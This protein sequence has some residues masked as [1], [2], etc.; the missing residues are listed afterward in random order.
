[1]VPTDTPRYPLESKGTVCRGWQLLSAQAVALL[2][3]GQH[4]GDAVLG[5]RVLSLAMA[6]RPSGGTLG[7][8]GESAALPRIKFVPQIHQIW[9]SRAEHT[10]AGSTEGDRASGRTG[11]LAQTFFNTYKSYAR[12]SLMSCI[13]ISHL[14]HPLVVCR[15][16]ERWKLFGGKGRGFSLQKTAISIY[17]SFAFTLS[18]S[19]VQ[20]G[21][22]RV[23]LR[24]L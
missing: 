1:M 18:A 4:S 19:P 24:R 22:G 7:G 3:V 13:R 14:P 21:R 8:C 16:P 23:W 2:E 11:G 9:L 10:G 5:R 17:S 12:A 15:K 20:V 6:K